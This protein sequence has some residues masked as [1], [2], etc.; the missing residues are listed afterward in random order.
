MLICLTCLIGLQYIVVRHTH[1][2]GA[3]TEIYIYTAKVGIR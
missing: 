2:H 1:M 3:Y